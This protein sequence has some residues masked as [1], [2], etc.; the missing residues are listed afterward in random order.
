MEQ[1]QRV[2][3]RSREQMRE[4]GWEGCEI[5]R[6]CPGPVEWGDGGKEGEWKGGDV[7]VRGAGEGRTVVW[8][9]GERGRKWVGG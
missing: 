6:D 3:G 2:V 4:G 5:W 1:A 7:R 9:R 8:W